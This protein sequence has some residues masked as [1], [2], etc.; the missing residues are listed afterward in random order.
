MIQRA[1]TTDMQM[2]SHGTLTLV[3]GRYWPLCFQEFRSESLLTTLGGTAALNTYSIGF[4]G[5]ETLGHDFC[6]SNMR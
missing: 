6:Q 1:Q 3:Y 4:K 2:A 5:I